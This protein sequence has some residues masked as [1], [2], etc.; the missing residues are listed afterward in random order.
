MIDFNLRLA[1]IFHLLFET[2]ACP[3]RRN[4]SA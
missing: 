3:R 2:K 4:G 1:G